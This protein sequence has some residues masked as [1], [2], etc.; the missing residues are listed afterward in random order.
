MLELMIDD[1]E[2]FDTVKEEFITI[3]GGLYQLEHSLKAIRLWEA[4]YKKP[5]LT[6]EQTKGELLDYF[7]MM[8]VGD[9]KLLPQQLTSESYHRI[10]K[11]LNDPQSATTVK[12]PPGS[13]SKRI[14]TAETIY[15]LMS[16][17]NVPYSCEEWNINSLLMLLK[18]ISVQTGTK[19]KMSRSDI[20]RQNTELNAMRRA[21]LNT[22][23]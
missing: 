2:V 5:F 18:V 19:T 9:R 23:G 1:V 12:S 17:T 22:R 4:K 15:A 14:M 7:T 16:M 6:G 10:S 13:S 8:V 3:S 21:A 11:Y 20:Y